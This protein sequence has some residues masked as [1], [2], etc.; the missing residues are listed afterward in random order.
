VLAVTAVEPISRDIFV[1]RDNEDFAWLFHGRVVREFGLGSDT[2]HPLNDF[3]HA[4]VAESLYAAQL[5]LA[6]LIRVSRQSSAK[7]HER[8]LERGH[9]RADARLVILI[10]DMRGL[11]ND[12]KYAANL[13]E[14]RYA[15]RREG[16]AALRYWLLNKGFGAS[17]VDTVLAAHLEA[18]DPLSDALALLQKRFGDERSAD[19]RYPARAWN[20]LISRGYSSGIA[21]HA[22]RR[23][24]REQ[25]DDPEY[26]QD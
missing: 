2:A 5:S 4:A 15:R 10:A 22:L 7:Y 12:D 26:S 13:L 23:F 25:E 1:I 16:R 11:I 24:F 9:G 18:V 21:Q 3:F 17:T 6:S 20:F 19:G 8:L 14:L